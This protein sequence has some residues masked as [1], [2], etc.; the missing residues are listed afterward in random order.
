MSN[1]P[2]NLRKAAVLIRSLDEATAERLLAALPPGDAAAV[3]AA[4]AT[5]KDVDPEEQ[6]DVVAEMRRAAAVAGA[7]AATGVELSLSSRL[8]GDAGKT[9]ATSAVGWD[10]LAER[11][12]QSG[13][14]T[15]DMRF[16]FLERAPTVSLV[17]YLARE[18][19]QTIAVV[20]S[21]LA[22]ARAAA[23]LAALPP[24]QQADTLERL[25][26]IG[27]TDP[28]SLKIVEQELAA[29]VAAQ[30]TEHRGTRNG[31]VAK[32]ILAA[33][34]PAAREAIM[35]N[36]TSRKRHVAARLS[37]APKARTATGYERQVAATP[38]SPAP[39]L[40]T[41]LD[42]LRATKVAA[43]RPA[44]AAPAPSKRAAAPAPPMQTAKPRLQFEDLGRLDAQ[45]LATI[46][47]RVEPNLLV[48]ALTGCG[49]ELVERIAAQLP[50]RIAKAVRR[51]LRN[52][53]PT[54]LSDVEA[55]QQTI[56][57]TAMQVNE[58]ETALAGATR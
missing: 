18:H 29:W 45:S 49:E 46:V 1:L 36:V 28:D 15:R 16:G 42:A 51:Q 17:P 48:L 52:V 39:R 7:G 53:G 56:A 11:L 5:L 37:D 44:S 2:A 54:R 21:Y 14:Q 33:A 58:Q 23:V 4:V 24:Q 38:R 47:Q 30:A 22:P 19:A 20:L 3:R 31:A 41:Q 57:N 55:A 43:A 25:N 34:S 8:A 10:E 40:S 32:A 6:A 26:T 50:K 12:S 13:T 9:L 35:A 27:E